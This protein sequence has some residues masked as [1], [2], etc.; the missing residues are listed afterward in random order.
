MK[1]AIILRISVLLLI[2]G[3]LASCA[4][5]QPTSYRT[6]V[7]AHCGFQ[8]YKKPKQQKRTQAPPSKTT[9]IGGNYKVRS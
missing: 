1:T 8:E 3:L 5:S 7:P 9:P 6:S 2:L 4:S